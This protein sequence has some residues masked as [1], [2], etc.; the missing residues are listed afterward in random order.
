MGVLGVEVGLRC[1]LEMG[2]AGVRGVRAAGQ[3]GQQRQRYELPVHDQASLDGEDK[4][5]GSEL[6]PTG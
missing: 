5:G 4:T 6:E 3:S 2:F 1:F